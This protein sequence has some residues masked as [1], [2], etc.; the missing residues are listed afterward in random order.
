MK[1]LSLFVS[2]AFTIA[3]PVASAEAKPCPREEAIYAYD[4]EDEDATRTVF[5][6][7][8]AQRSEL[9]PRA[10]EISFETWRKDKLVWSVDGEISC[11]DVVP[12]CNLKL[13]RTAHSST[14]EESDQCAAFPLAVE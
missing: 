11:S 7:Q 5:K 9:P 8:V 14:D 1:K 4:W 10:Q 2:L 3:P 6:L 12:M 13:D